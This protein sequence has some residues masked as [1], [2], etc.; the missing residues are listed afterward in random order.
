[1]KINITGRGVI[2]GIGTIPPVYNRELSEMAISRLLNF[3]SFKLYDSASGMLITK[4]NL[5]E[6]IANSNATQSQIEDTS[7]VVVATTPVEENVVVEASVETAPIT[8]DYTHN[9]SGL[10][11]EDVTP[12]V[13]TPVEEVTEDTVDENTTE[14]IEETIVEETVDDSAY[15]AENKNFN[16]HKKNKKHR[17]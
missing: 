15:T 2:P 11:T 5:T 1:M 14:T 6:I 16:N 7:D 12:V 10:I 8:E 9:E 13:E 4:K 3:P 17:N